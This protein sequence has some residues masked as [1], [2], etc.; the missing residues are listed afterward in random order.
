MF[1]LDI[2][3]YIQYTQLNKLMIVNNMKYIKKSLWLA[4]AI[5]LFMPAL[6]LFSFNAVI[7][8]LVALLTWTPAIAIIHEVIYN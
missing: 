6:Y 5:A 2:V 7:C 1:L 3:K 8:F 4:T